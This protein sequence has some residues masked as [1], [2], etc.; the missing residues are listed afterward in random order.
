MVK[1]LISHCPLFLKRLQKVLVAGSHANN[2]GYQCGGWTIQWQGLGGNN[3]T[4]DQKVIRCCFA[5][6]I[7]RMIDKETLNVRKGSFIA[8][9]FPKCQRGAA[10]ALTTWEKVKIRLDPGRAF[11]KPN[12]CLDNFPGRT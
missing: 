3:L 4:K 12:G 10:P 9:S 6:R 11:V 5:V 7:L 8:G 1:N 2:L